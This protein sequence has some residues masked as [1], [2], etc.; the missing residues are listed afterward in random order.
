MPTPRTILLRSAARTAIGMSVLALSAAV[1]APAFGAGDGKALPP[2]GEDDG[3]RGNPAAKDR[4]FCCHPGKHGTL[5]GRVIEVD[6]PEPPPPLYTAWNSES[7]RWRGP[8]ANRID[9]VFVGDGY[10]ADDLALYR[11]HVESAW[12]YLESRQPY[13]S[14]RRYFNVHRVD[15]LSA[16]QGVDN[17]PTQGI[18]RNTALDMAFWADGETERFLGVDIAKAQQ[19]AGCAPDWDQVLAVANSTKYGGIAWAAADVGTFS[20]ANAQSFQVAEHE[21]GHSFGDLADEYDYDADPPNY[22]GPEIDARNVSIRDRAT[23][24]ADNAKWVDW[25]G[26]SLPGV[27]L[28]DCYEGGFYH[29]TGVY[30]PTSDSLMRTL[31]Q[32]FNGPSIEQMI[33][34]I[35]LATKMADSFTHAP[36]STFRA[37]SEVSAV[38][39]EPFDRPLVKVW[40]VGGVVVPG[41]TG[42]SFETGTLDIPP[43]GTSLQLEVIDDNPL[44]RN[45]F[46]KFFVMREV[47]SWVLLPPDGLSCASAVTVLDSSPAS[48][49][50]DT[51]VDV[52]PSD[53]TPCGTS[54]QWAVWRRI[55][56]PCTG[57]MTVTACP[58]LFASGE[59]TL[60]MA[61]ECGPFASCSTTNASACVPL[62]SGVIRFGV[63]LGE[64]YFIRISAAGSGDVAGTLS[65]SCAAGCSSGSCYEARSTPGCSVA[66]CC[67]TTCTADP[68]CCDSAWDQL[69]VDRANATCRSGLYCSQARHINPAYPS[70]YL[71]NTADQAWPGGSSECGSMD[72]REIWR[73]YT[74]T[75]SGMMTVGICTEFAEAQT[76]LA[77]YAADPATGV[78]PEGAPS[79]LVC[80]ASPA[81][82][83]GLGGSVQLRWPVLAGRTYLLRIA[84]NQDRTAAGSL[85]VTT[86]A[87]CGTGGPCNE[88]RFTPGCSDAECCVTVCTADPYCCTVAW[89]ATCVQES[90]TLCGGGPA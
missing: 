42:P 14:Y 22:T 82:G 9:M 7:I 90:G 4:V 62:S 26:V 37:G 30:R 67:A 2:A 54:D 76:T 5:E 66:S 41:A 36:G 71:F 6:L 46:F 31:S 55:V 53:E 10:Q 50:F 88:P 43:G 38:L 27:G 56:A 39:V 81:P 8:T 83:C 59:V 87:V 69:C 52:D 89:D 47:Y 57:V 75:T 29:Q 16:D 19:A 80:S 11:N 15:V 25:L 79:A 78:C 86:T 32:P 18:L 3:V 77:L 17:D 72:G 48:K 51:R 63:V 65:V 60:A 45:E 33:V 40:R 84:A 74:P 34:K 35:H 68:F 58:T 12:Q 85:T 1:A 28:H 61:E 13:A 21:L 64:D 73:S 70:S 44:V 20:G 23:M 49:Q 24:I